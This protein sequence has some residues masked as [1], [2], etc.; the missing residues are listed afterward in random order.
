[1]IEGQAVFKIPPRPV[2]YLFMSRR[3]ASAK[4]RGKELLE[5]LSCSASRDYFRINTDG[6]S[7]VLLRV[8]NSQG[9]SLWLQEMLK[10]ENIWGSETQWGKADPAPRA[11]ERI[12]LFLHQTAWVKGKWS[13][14]AW[15]K[16]EGEIV[17]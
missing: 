8:G 16:W 2:R 10:N 14:M 7:A 6:V 17:K 12:L 9:G 5:L 4:R 1:M 3:A 11:G 15:E 13:Q